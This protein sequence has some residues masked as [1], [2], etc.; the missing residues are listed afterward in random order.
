V[1]HRIKTLGELQSEFARPSVVVRYNHPCV[2]VLMSLQPAVLTRM[3]TVTALRISAF[4]KRS[5]IGR[6]PLLLTVLLKLTMTSLTRAAGIALSS[7]RHHFALGVAR[8][9]TSTDNF[10][11]NLKHSKKRDHSLSEGRRRE[12]IDIFSADLMPNDS[13]KL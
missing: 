10:S 12:H 4:S 6:S 2:S 7:E 8:F 9:G 1:R 11:D 3:L 13:G 5:L